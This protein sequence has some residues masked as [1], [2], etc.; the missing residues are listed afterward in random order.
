MKKSDEKIIELIKQVS[1]GELVEAIDTLDEAVVLCDNERRE[2]IASIV[3]EDFN[4][5]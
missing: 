2:K 4:N 5:K 1:D 3:E